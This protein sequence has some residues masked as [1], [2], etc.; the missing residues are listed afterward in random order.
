MGLTAASLSQFAT[1]SVA[2]RNALWY[3]VLTYEGVD[4]AC[5]IDPDELTQMLE[6]AGMNQDRSLT[7]EVPNTAGLNASL[8][9]NITIKT[10]ATGALQGMTFR[11]RRMLPHPDNPAV[12]YTLELPI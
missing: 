5:N 9:K 6:S 1:R 7:I 2:A 10:T 3:S 8:G 11:I 12:I 4:Y